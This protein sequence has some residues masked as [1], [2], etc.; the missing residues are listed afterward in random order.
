MGKAEGDMEEKVLRILCNNLSKQYG[1]EQQIGLQWLIG[2]SFMPFTVI[3]SL[4]CLHTDGDPFAPNYAAEA[5]DLRVLLPRGLKVVGALFVSDTN[6]RDNAIKAG[7]ICSK[8]RRYLLPMQNESSFVIGVAATINT[9]DTEY[10]M[11][12]EGKSSSIEAFKTVIHEEKSA[13]YLWDTACLLH[14]QMS[15][16][17][18]VY[19][20]SNKSSEEQFSLVVEDFAANLKGPRAVFQAESVANQSEDCSPLLL[21]YMDSNVGGLDKNIEPLKNNNGHWNE[22]YLLCSKLCSTDKCLLSASGVEI[23]EPIKLTVLHQSSDNVKARAPSVGFFP[24]QEDIRLIMLVIKLDVLCLASRELSLADAVSKLL[25]PGLID[26]LSAMRKVSDIRT[27]QPKLCAYHFCPPGFLHPLTAVYDLS[28]GETEMEQVEVRKRLHVRLKLPLDRPMVR[29]A[30]ALTLATTDAVAGSHPKIKG[31]MRLTN[32]HVGLS[33]SGVAGGQMCLLEG[34]YEYYHYL[35]DDFDDNGWGCAYRSLQTIISWFRL[36]HYTSVDVPSH[37]K[38]Q[39]TLVEIG[40]KEP[41]FTGSREWIGA[42]ELSFVLDKL[43]G[44]SC[45]ILNVRSGAELPEK[46]RELA[47]HFETQGTPVMIGGGVLAYTLLGVDYN[48]LTGDCAF[49]ILDPHYTGTDDLKSIQAG[50]W[51]GWKKAVSA[52]GKEFFL[53]DKFYNLLLPQ[54]PNMV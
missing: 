34:S 12:M 8:L 49:L 40:D 9:D 47:L 21:R 25:I 46:C 17:L 6:G 33:S 15:L 42:I 38:I 13:Q 30:N 10:F 19:L 1:K 43:L 44:V 4:K 37:R 54:R 2:V 26:Q 41:S 50:G 24:A 45:R 51:C 5:D 32:V 7:D 23:P 53:R 48:E 14:C 31:M 20:S 16:N 3:S 29:V 36:Q 18:P 35:Q 52:K 28:F 22:D 39:E 27:K 11:Y